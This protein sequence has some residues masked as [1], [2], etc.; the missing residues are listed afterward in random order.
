MALQTRQASAA[1]ATTASGAE[2]LAAILADASAAHQPLYRDLESQILA[3]SQP[4]RRVLERSA[5]LEVEVRDLREEMAVSR[6]RA[7]EQLV[8]ARR[9]AVKAEQACWP[10]PDDQRIC[11]L[12]HTFTITHT[13]PA[14][15]P[16]VRAGNG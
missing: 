5:Q 2:A 1:V 10:S 6:F 7:E 16:L 9:E 14:D 12:M 15:T 13:Q 8:E 3:I 4:L 11:A